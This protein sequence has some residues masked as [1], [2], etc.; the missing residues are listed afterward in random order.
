MAITR[1]LIYED[2]SHIEAFG[3]NVKGTLNHLLYKKWL[4]YLPDLRPDLV[5]YNDRKLAVFNDAYYICTIVLMIKSCD[6]YL[7]YYLKQT[8]IPSVV[9]PMVFLY[10]SRLDIQTQ[11]RIDL[12]KVIE[13]AT[14]IHEDWHQNLICLKK[15][16]KTGKCSINSSA[17]K[18]RDYTPEFLLGIDW[19]EVTDNFTVQGINKVLRHLAKNEEETNM[20]LDAIKEGVNKAENDYLSSMI[21][22]NYTPDED[23][24]LIYCNPSDDVLDNCP[25]DFFDDRRC[26]IDEI[27]ENVPVLRL[28]V[29]PTE[30]TLENISDDVLSDFESLVIEPKYAEKV[31][32]RIHELIKGQTRPKSIVMPIRAAMDAGVMKRP[33]WGQFITEFGEDLIKS[34]TSFSNWTN[35]DTHSY[36][37]DAF[38]TMKKNFKDMIENH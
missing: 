25:M 20:I 31:V 6:Q 11:E 13:A 28:E 38:E 37:G 34:K 3:I 32:Q 27:K 4:L 12:L 8:K 10:V 21:P 33:T 1:E 26:L 35:S 17:F 16:V 19:R 9:I 22:D 24:E 29:R 36:F 7:S 18:R 30:Q 23:S 5:G 14:K 15:A 2:K